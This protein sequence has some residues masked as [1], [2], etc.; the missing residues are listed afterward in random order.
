MCICLKLK[1]IF[2]YFPIRAL[3]LDEIDNWDRFPIVFITLDGDAWDPHTSHYAIAV[4][5]SYNFGFANIY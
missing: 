4:M 5:L 1:G 2:S 3:T